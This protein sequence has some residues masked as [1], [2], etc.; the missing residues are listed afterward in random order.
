MELKGKNIA[1]IGMGNTGLATA[2]F[3][4]KRGGRVA[5]YDQKP[6]SEIKG[7]DRIKSGI[8][9]VDAWDGNALGSCD[10]AVV[11]PGV[12]MALRG[13]QSAKSEGR[14][15]ISEVELASRFTDKKIIGITGTNGKTTTVTLLGQILNNAGKKAGVG[16][17][18]GTPFIRLV[19]HDRDYE[20]YLLELSSYQLEGIVR[21]RPWIAGLLNIT[22]DHLDRYKDINDYAKAKLRIFMNQSVDDYAVINAEDRYTV[23]GKRNITSRPYCFTTSKRTRRGAYYKN[24]EITFIDGSGYKTIFT[25]NNPSLAGMHNVQNTMACII[26]AKLLDIPDGII[27]ETINSFKGLPHRIELVADVNGIKFYDDSKATNVDAVVV[28]L[29]TMSGPVILIMGGRDKEGDYS[30]LSGLIR[31]KVKLLVVMGEAKER[32]TSAFR[33]IVKILPVDSMESAVASAVHH[34]G[35]GDSV[36][37]SPAC[38]S[39]DMFLDYK[40]R[41]EMFKSAVMNINRST[42]HEGL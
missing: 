33:D 37:L 23:K 27:Q 17:N 9:V 30:P 42:T 31:E 11:S 5:C 34:A 29:K 36:L 24:G 20:L 26:I 4:L 18:I 22:D 8:T 7:I 1:I 38:S 12:P 40:Q 21:F 16:G 10:L 2:D 41:G 39:F 6:V 3:V 32:I 25:H 19:E 35:R 13:I 15:V 28:A 14:E